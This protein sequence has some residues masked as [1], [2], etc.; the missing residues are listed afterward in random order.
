M[1]ILSKVFGREELKPVR[2]LEKPRP[3]CPFY[4]FHG[5][6]EAPF[7]SIM[8]SEGNQ[9]ALTGKYSPCGMEMAHETPSWDGC[10]VYNHPKNIEV[11]RKVVNSSET[12][13]FPREFTPEGANYWQGMPLKKWFHYI[14][15][16]DL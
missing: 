7:R 15:G 6:L 5:A 1:G 13:A 3:K 8:D 11:L 2:D 14:V 10:T 16:R 4:G 9:C 12:K